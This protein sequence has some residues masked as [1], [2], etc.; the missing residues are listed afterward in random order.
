MK[1]PPFHFHNPNR[2]NMKAIKIFPF[3]LTIAI[4][5]SSCHQQKLQE[6]DEG[7][8]TYLW[9]DSLDMSLNNDTATVDIATISAGTVDVAKTVKPQH[10]DHYDKGYGI[11]F[12]NGR[13][14]AVMDLGDGWSYDDSNPYTGKARQDYERG[15][16]KGYRDGYKDGFY[17]YADGDEDEYDEY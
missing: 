9:D 16:R 13:E 14:D 5:A 15:Y 2:H 8:D 6:G 17:D 12:D 4:L 11:G 3:L 10:I 1:T 7:D